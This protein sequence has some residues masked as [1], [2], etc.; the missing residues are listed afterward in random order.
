[1]KAIPLTIKTLQPILATSFQGDPNSDV[2]YPYL[3]GSMIRGAIIGRYMKH[4]HLSDLDLDNS[5]VKRLFFDAD[6]T[7]YLN[8]YLVSENNK[9]TLPSLR[10]W[11]KDKNAEV[12]EETL[13]HIYD[14]ITDSDL[15]DNDREKLKA[16]ERYFWAN[17]GGGICFY[18]EKR[19]INI[20]NFRDRQKGR[21]TD[22]QGEIFRYEAL[23]AEQ[24]FQ[25]IILCDDEDV[26][27][28]HNFLVDPDMWFGGSQSAGYGHTKVTLGK[29]I[30]NWCE[31]DIDDREEH[32]IFSVTL[33]SD[34]ILRN[35]CGQAVADLSLVKEAIEEILDIQ[36]P[37]INMNK[38]FV[39][40]TLIGGF[41]RKWGLPLPQVQALAAGSV[42]VFKPF[43]IS[44]QH[45]QEIEARG[46]GERRED[47]FGRLAVNLNDRGTLTVQ[48][49][50]VD[51]RRN[52]ISLDNR[53]SEKLAG[54]MVQ[55][56]LA[57][58]LEQQV[59]KKVSYLTLDLDEN[60]SNSQL[61]RLQLVARQ[62]LVNRDLNYINNFFEKLPT[63]TKNQF[64][65]AKIAN[66]PFI[67]QIE[68]WL[69]NPE[70]WI[71]NQPSVTVA[72]ISKTLTPELAREYTI[73]LI[74]AVAKKASKEKNHER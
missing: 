16:L 4:H 38:T 68:E 8:A 60:I 48:L 15:E 49:A 26:T 40:S 31:I 37:S 62:A 9:R 12:K 21:A 18:K 45:I 57:R 23:D 69:E 46:I 70:E 43:E 2:S 32:D 30:E 1:M 66:K 50:K 63:N 71:E 20:H 74:M 5:E 61:S 34:T 65:R 41:N 67:K 42:I 27:K 52:L 36:L 7:R 3:P 55:R 25:S 17:E 54:E 47:G 14:F 44:D 13:I 33:L 35:A 56:I 22:K 73:R 19:R 6:H 24:V 28:F 53:Y 10:S 39:D 58:K 72:T 29:A 59:Q 64:E 11:R 51:R